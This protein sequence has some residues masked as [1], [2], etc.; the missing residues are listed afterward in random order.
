[1]YRRLS[2]QPRG[3]EDHLTELL[4]SV[5]HRSYSGAILQ[6][7]RSTASAAGGASPGKTPGAWLGRRAKSGRSVNKRWSCLLG[8]DPRSRSR[9]SSFFRREISW[10][11]AA[12]GAYGGLAPPAPPPRPPGGGPAPRPAPPP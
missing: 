10:R 7:G 5:T 8:I 2:G 6:P 4:D 9:G 3:K 11:D 1:M 12:G